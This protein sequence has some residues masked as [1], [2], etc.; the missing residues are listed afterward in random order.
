MDQEQNVLRM[1]A[2][3]LNQQFTLPGR[4]K[5]HEWRTFDIHPLLCLSVRGQTW[6]DTVW[7]HQTIHMTGCIW[8]PMLRSNTLHLAGKTLNCTSELMQILTHPQDIDAVWLS[9]PLLGDQSQLPVFLEERATLPNSWTVTELVQ[10][11]LWQIQGELNTIPSHCI[12]WSCGMLTAFMLTNLCPVKESCWQV[13]KFVH[14]LGLPD[15]TVWLHFRPIHLKRKKKSLCCAFSCY[16][17][18]QGE[19][20]FHCD[21]M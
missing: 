2:L 12:L 21:K 19:A 4:W 8:S 20:S 10:A 13:V 18:M 3:D 7:W 15:S 17:G 16:Y 1:G 6:S 9:V 14:H 5:E 11:D